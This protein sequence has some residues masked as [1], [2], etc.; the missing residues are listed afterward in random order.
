MLQQVVAHTKTGEAHG[1]TIK[2][3]QDTLCNSPE[4]LEAFEGA[5]GITRTTEQL[6]SVISEDQAFNVDEQSGVLAALP[7][8]QASINTSLEMREAPGNIGRRAVVAS[9]SGSG[10]GSGSRSSPGSNL[11]V[12]SNFGG[13]RL[14][15]SRSI[16]PEVNLADDAAAGI[17][18]G[19]VQRGNKCDTCLTKQ[20]PCNVPENSATGMCEN[21]AVKGER[22]PP[23]SFVHY[24]FGE[25]RSPI[26]IQLYHL[27]EPR[28]DR[29]GK[30]YQAA[31]WA[32]ATTH[33]PVASAAN[34][35]GL[36]HVPASAL[37]EVPEYSDA[38]RNLTELAYNLGKGYVVPVQAVQEVQGLVQ[39]LLQDENLVA[40]QRDSMERVQ[41]VLADVV[42]LAGP[43]SDDKNM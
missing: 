33:P 37:R 16:G 21:C 42:A 29:L 41:K 17:Q 1:L 22:Y 10:S 9:T 4:Y 19:P 38:M 20:L 11:G 30:A 25:S 32:D 39:D 23:C 14:G 28:T 36:G 5:M 24:R 7:L 35:G 27:R 43:I 31:R 8:E 3:I 12:G 13:S 34:Q 18:P 6:P 40:A 2:S 15:V 26:S